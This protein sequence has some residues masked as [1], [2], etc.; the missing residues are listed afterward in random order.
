[1]RRGRAGAQPKMGGNAAA[2]HDPAW[3]SETM[4]DRCMTCH[5]DIRSQ[6]DGKGPL[7]GTLSAGM[8]C[9]SCHTEHQGSHSVLT[10]MAKFDHDCAAFK[11]TGAHRKADCK[12]CHVNSLY[13]STAQTCI[14]CHA[15]PQVHLGRFGTGC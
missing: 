5:T 1:A 11:L 2:C 15:E 9:R 13:K 10:N 7:H 4:A 8:E 12:S 6:L 3:S 14:S